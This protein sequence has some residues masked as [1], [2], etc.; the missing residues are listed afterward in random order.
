MAERRSRKKRKARQAARAQA[1]GPA[2]AAQAEAERGLERGYARSRR[3]DE[4]AR[5]AL[6]PLAP[7]ERPGAVTVAVV[8]AVAFAV[9]NVVALI[10]G[11]DSDEG[12]KTASTILGAVVLI[13]M[14]VG[15]WRVRY[16]AVLGM[17]ALLA[18]SIV[19]GALALLGA[20]N[21]RGA[22]LAVAI[23]VAAGTLFWRLVKAMARIQMPTRPGTS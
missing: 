8:V 7:G 20:G 2:E 21:W 14:A 3:R 18:I 5:A 10:A 6:E 12:G 16:W 4:E 19:L 15:M 1:S 23:V 17:Q 11:Y 22:L 13:V 9:A